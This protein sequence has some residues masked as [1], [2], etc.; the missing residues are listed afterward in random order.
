MHTKSL[1]I[2]LALT[3][4][5]AAQK[6]ARY[7]Q[8]SLPG[9]SRTL[10]LAEVEVISGGKNIAREGK[11]SQSSTASNGPAEKAIDGNKNPDYTAGGQTHT[12]EGGKNPW[13]ELDL[14]K[15]V[16]IENISV[17]NRG[18]GDLGQRLEGFT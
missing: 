6:E 9:N 15:S 1:S 3:S 12:Q 2:L 8:I 16:S 13:W 10:T 5:A 4:V 17:W 11:A 18:E 14:G 7:V